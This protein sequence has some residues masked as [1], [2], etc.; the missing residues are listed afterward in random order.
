MNIYEMHVDGKYTTNVRAVSHRDAKETFT[1]LPGCKVTFKHV[2]VS[3]LSGTV[4][5]AECPSTD[6]KV[7]KNYM[8]LSSWAYIVGGH[9][10]TMECNKMPMLRRLGLIHPTENRLTA[11]GQEIVD[12][13]NKSRQTPFD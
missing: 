13:Y 7:L 4:T 5:F 8:T 9:Y 12:S 2:G 6:A 3:V 10:K 11:A 1:W